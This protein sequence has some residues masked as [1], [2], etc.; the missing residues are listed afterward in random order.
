MNRFTYTKQ[1]SSVSTL[2]G[3]AILFLFIICLFYFGM[4]SFSQKTDLEQQKNLETAL[5]QSMIHCYCVEGFYPEG[6]SY[7]EKHYGISYNK[8][9]F[10]VDYKP[11]GQNIMP[12]ITVILKDSPNDNI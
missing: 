2:W 10:F 7:L 3:S 1:K 6:L 4:S 12:D 9:K 5:Q 11:L 8:D